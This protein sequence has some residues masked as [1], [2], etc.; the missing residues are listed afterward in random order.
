M[1]EKRLSSHVEFLFA[2]GSPKMIRKPQRR[3]PFGAVSAF[4]FLFLLVLGPV[5]GARLIADAYGDLGADYEV[6]PWSIADTRDA[7]DQRFSEIL[8]DAPDRRQAWSDLVRRETDEG[9]LASARGLLLAGPVILDAPDAGSLE[10]FARQGTKA[11]DD[12][13]EEAALR[14]VSED[15]RETYE[16]ARRVTQAE[17][18][19]T[20]LAEDDRIYQNDAETLQGVAPEDVSYSASGSPNQ[21]SLN[22]LGSS[23]DLALEAARWM[24]NDDIDV[25]A[26]TLSGIGLSVIE[27]GDRAGV[28][29]LR[30]AYRA[31]RLNPDLLDYFEEKFYAVVPPS[32]LKRAL[33][34]ETGEAMSIVGQTGR[35]E[36]I[37]GK[38]ANRNALQDL[39][40]ELKIVTDIA[41]KSSVFNAITF[42]E[43]AR[44][45]ADLRRARLV[46]EAGGDKAIALARLDPAG[47]LHTA[48]AEI[49]WNNRMRFMLAS[50][51]AVAIVLS[52]LSVNMLVESFRRRKPRRRSAVYALEDPD[53]LT[54]DHY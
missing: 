48:K 5:I 15:T 17:W 43:S 4:L 38:V 52:W 7:I 12:A 29:I 20:S 39:E 49:P 33:F 27:E 2:F 41:E 36:E 24:R 11:G 30:S 9:R 25:F 19:T 53:W 23:R 42:L 31:G 16:R 54:A 32:R 6:T 1:I 3:V 8:T 50:L 26:F 21:I 35:I 51:A 40:V 34:E 14:Y 37:F 10:E 13:L 44:G 45:S 47:V 46:A 28:S 18:L 22:V